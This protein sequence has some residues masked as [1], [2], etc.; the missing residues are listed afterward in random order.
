[1]KVKLPIAAGALA[2]A[3]ATQPAIAQS[4]QATVKEL[5]GRA[6]SESGK[7]AV[8]ELID[9]LG[10]ARKG[11]AVPEPSPA[12][13]PPA[14]PR[15][16]AP[17]PLPAIAA[18]AVVPQPP[19]SPAQSPPG[20]GVPTPAAP[21]PVAVPDTA[22]P[23]VT[24]GQT[25]TATP[26]APTPESPPLVV[27]PRPRGPASLAIAPPASP[28]TQASRDQPTLTP[29]ADDPQSAA[30]PVSQPPSSPPGGTV[31]RSRVAPGQPIV[32]RPTVKSLIS[33]P[34]ATDAEMAKAP[35][36]AEKLNLPRAD[37]EVLFDLDSA[38]ITAPAKAT[39]GSLGAALADRRLAG[40]KFVVA[41]HTDGYGPD[42]YNI[43]LSQRRAQAVRQYMIEIFGID[44]ANLI[45]RGFG[46][47][48]LKNRQNPFAGENRRVQIINWTSQTAAE[49]RN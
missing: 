38:D 19:V 31:A 35:Q 14:A 12:A 15:V 23:T 22:P 1:M 21:Q 43:A 40:Q 36:M 47:S 25:T 2:L 48:Q 49:P 32:V 24:P 17:T 46:K 42:A 29:G 37:I 8:E 7:R 18:P 16:T 44:P 33:G 13:P 28:P 11:Q 6:Q 3:T 41:G 27:T 4:G 9:K 10:G 45:A 26:A 30:G 5:L 34:F 39:L 20:I